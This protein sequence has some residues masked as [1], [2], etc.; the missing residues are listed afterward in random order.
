MDKDLAQNSSRIIQKRNAK[1]KSKRRVLKKK[2]R[3][4][5][6]VVDANAKISR[7]EGLKKVKGRQA[8]NKQTSSREAGLNIPP[9]SFPWSTVTSTT[10]N[11]G[12][13][14]SQNLSLRSDSSSTT[15]TTTTTTDSSNRSIN[16]GG[17]YICESTVS[18]V[19][20]SEDVEMT[21]ATEAE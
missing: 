7:R 5:A 14:F 10:G 17:D 4:K 21:D 1:N 8:K 16:V 20:S 15:T 12:S 3:N 11:A 2:K 13:V 19:D 9:I 18:A 6:Q